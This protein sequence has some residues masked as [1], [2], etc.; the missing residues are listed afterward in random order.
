MLEALTTNRYCNTKQVRIVILE[1]QNF[2]MASITASMMLVG[3]HTAAKQRGQITKSLHVSNRDQTHSYQR[4]TITTTTIL[5]EINVSV[6]FCT[7]CINYNML[8]SF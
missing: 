7:D 3:R 2:S 5:C 4:I 1:T 6:T 8:H